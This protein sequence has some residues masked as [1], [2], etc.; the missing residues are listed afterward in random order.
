MSGLGN[1]IH[2]VEHKVD[3]VEKAVGVVGDGFAHFNASILD[4]VGLHSAANYVRHTGDNFADSLGAQ[5]PESELGLSDKATD[6][7]HGDPHAI[8]GAAKH[9][10]RL[11]GSFHE[12]AKGMRGVDT[13][14]WRGE[15]AD[16]FHKRFTPHPAKWTTAGDACEKAA[17]A[18]D[19]FAQTVRWAQKKAAEAIHEY[20]QGQEI[21]DRDRAA[22]NKAVDAYNSAAHKWAEAQS[23]PAPV[24]PKPFDDTGATKMALAEADLHDARVQRDKEA[25][26][27]QRLIKA[28]IAHAPKSPGFSL[29][30]SLKDWET[31]N[32]VS[33]E[34]FIGGFAKGLGGLVKFLRGVDPTD[35]YNL[36]HPNFYLDHLTGT[37]AGLLHAGN[38]PGALVKSIVGTGWKSDFSQ[39]LGNLTANVTTAV[40]TDGADVPEV[41]AADSAADGTATSLA[42]S[43]PKEPPPPPPISIGDIAN[44]A[45]Q[46]VLDDIRLVPRPVYDRFMAYANQVPGGGISIDA[47]PL[48]QLP[49]GEHLIAPDGWPEGATWDDRAGVYL[50][51]QRRLFINSEAPRGVT[52]VA[53]HEFG[54]GAD[55]AYGHLSAS[56]EWAALQKRVVDELGNRPDWNTYFNNPAELFAESF[57]AWTEG[58]GILQKVTLGNEQLA[59]ELRDYF[60]RAF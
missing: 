25:D 17:S 14:H 11:G 43:L 21:S 2:G 60:E 20:A 9:L 52:S 13:G 41:A 15:A 4:H 7:I 55:F 23:G 42:E 36:A 5:V 40:V 48:T 54:H 53:L 8:E 29:T 19:G 24:A 45:T 28:A 47:K 46:Q 31:Y 59:N 16:A 44:P 39:A 30:R 33:G 51:H 3:Q 22:Y 10:S 49:G 38:H 34:H 18:L 58:R 32:L 26:H 35:P 1:F 12:V 37:A 6:L 56:P 27:A 50:S 57:A